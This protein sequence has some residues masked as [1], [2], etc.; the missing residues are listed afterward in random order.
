MGLA[1]GYPVV[2][3]IQNSEQSRFGGSNL[4]GGVALAA[5]VGV[6]DVAAVAIEVVVATVGVVGPSSEVAGPSSEAAAVVAPVLG[7]KKEVPRLA[8]AVQ[9]L[10]GLRLQEAVDSSLPSRDWNLE[11]LSLAGSNLGGLSLQ[12]ESAM[13][14]ETQ[15]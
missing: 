6:V 8:S 15:T 11:D 3:Q 7:G 5:V 9:F 14:V 4:V 1:S 12:T 13:E 2:G 10:Q